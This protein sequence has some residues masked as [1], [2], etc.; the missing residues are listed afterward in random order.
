M[1]FERGLERWPEDLGLLVQVAGQTSQ[2]RDWEK[3]DDL[4]R[5]RIL[6]DEPGAA[7]LYVHRARLHVQAGNLYDSASDLTTALRLASRSSSVHLRVGDTYMAMG[8]ADEA[9]RSWN[10]ALFLLEQGQDDPRSRVLR[11]LARLEEE[12]GRHGTA[13]RHWRAILSLDPADEEARRRLTALTGAS[14]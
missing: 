7:W 2:A 14:P 10:R 4:L 13:L 3:L 11:R 8:A 9:R 1:W 6:P 5:G 12:Q